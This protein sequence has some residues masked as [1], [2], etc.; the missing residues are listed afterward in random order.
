MSVVRVLNESYQI[1]TS[2]PSFWMVFKN[3]CTIVLWTKVALA[4]EGLTHSLE[5][6][7]KDRIMFCDLTKHDSVFILNFVN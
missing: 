3:L 2:M 6:P 1:N 4:S 5:I 7:N